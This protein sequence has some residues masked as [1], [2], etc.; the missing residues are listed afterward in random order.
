MIKMSTFDAMLNIFI[1]IILII[2]III[3]IIIITIIRLANEDEKG[4]MNQRIVPS[5][6]G[7]YASSHSS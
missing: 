6:S 4:S 3:I 2:L 5:Q 7:S 1:I